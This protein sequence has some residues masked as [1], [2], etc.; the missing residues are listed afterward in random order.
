MPQKVRVAVCG[1]GR[2]G[3]IHGANLLTCHLADVVA[4]VELEA[5]FESATLALQGM[6]VDN[7]ASL[8]VSQDAFFNNLVK[9]DKIDAVVITTPT[10]DH[11]RWV[12]GTLT[13][14]FPI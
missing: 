10:P 7:P 13:L 3:K 14:I 4:V 9:S 2:A 5:A 6:G 11:T 1:F 12:Q 8:L